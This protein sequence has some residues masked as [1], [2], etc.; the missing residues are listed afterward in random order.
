MH[1]AVLPT[2]DRLGSCLAVWVST[3]FKKLKNRILISV[4]KHNWLT[5]VVIV[6]G[7][8]TQSICG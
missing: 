1:Y 2:W 7:K 4:R 5:I 8:E 6:V 3:E